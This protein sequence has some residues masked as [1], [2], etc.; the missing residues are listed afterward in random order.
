MNATEL[1]NG[2]YDA[3]FSWGGDAGSKVTATL[4]KH[5]KGWTCD[6]VNGQEWV[7]PGPHNPF[8]E[9]AWG[10]QVAKDSAEE[11]IV[12]F[13]EQWDAHDE[14]GCVTTIS[15]LSLTLSE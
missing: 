8:D 11:A 1:S 12:G 14:H 10:F 13:L 15:E 4:R 5:D 7:Y 6:D 9:N 3:T 2:T